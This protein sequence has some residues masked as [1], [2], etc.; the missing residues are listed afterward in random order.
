MDYSIETA[1]LEELQC[2]CVIVGVY[3][4][5]Q[6]SPS[7]T[8][9]NNS[10]NGLINNIVSRG[11]LSGK[12]GETVLINAVPGSKIER[13]LLVGLG[14]NKPLSG[15]NYKKNLAGRRQ[16]P[17]KAAN[18]IGRLLPGGMRC[19]RPRPAMEISTNHRSF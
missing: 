12:N 14:E 15:K 2:D 4:D 19:D 10:T 5:Q 11:D 9:L 8:A 18:K 13:I 3:Q 6:L 16:Q 17:E 7:A 1:P